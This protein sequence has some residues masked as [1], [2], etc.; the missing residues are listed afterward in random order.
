ML[1][2]TEH[3]SLVT[4]VPSRRLSKDPKDFF[5]F[6]ESVRYLLIQEK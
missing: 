1:E 3:V 5:Y 6:N 2:A 4:R